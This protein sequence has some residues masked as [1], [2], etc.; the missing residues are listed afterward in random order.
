MRA[1]DVRLVIAVAG[2][3][4]LAALPSAQTPADSRWWTTEPVRLIQT[5]ISETDSTTDPATLVSA[6]AEFGANTFLLNMGGIV[7]VSDD[8]AISLPKRLPSPGT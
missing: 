2:V 5:N 3:L 4:L 1:H 7:A 8:R 6:V